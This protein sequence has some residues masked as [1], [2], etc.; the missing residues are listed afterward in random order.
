MSRLLLL[1]VLLAL[2]LVA[3]E[4]VA[5]P[6]PEPSIPVVGATVKCAQGDHGIDDPQ[7]GWGFCYPGSWRFRERSQRIE[8]PPGVDTT[9]DIV[10][11]TSTGPEAGRFGFMVVSTYG[12]G[13]STTLAQWI[14]RNIDKGVELRQIKWGNARESVQAVSTGTR[15]ALTAHHVVSL[16]L[17]GGGDNLDLEG[18]M[19]RRLATWNFVF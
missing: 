1:V 19:G 13:D 16:E 4:S 17:R 15:Y 8:T 7:L 6:R 10:N 5:G 12:T 9:F 3:C 11:S 18:A 14:E 2:P